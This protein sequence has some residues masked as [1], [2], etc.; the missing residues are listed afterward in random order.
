M[1]H[2]AVAASSGLAVSSAADPLDD[3]DSDASA[4]AE[5]TPSSL[6]E[7]RGS[8]DAITIPANIFTN[9]PDDTGLGLH[10]ASTCA[11]ISNTRYCARAS[12]IMK[13]IE[14]ATP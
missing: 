14:I 9:W 10:I 7:G 12:S 8:K 13:G 6:A 5:S 11:E 4:S 1:T 2:L 3:S